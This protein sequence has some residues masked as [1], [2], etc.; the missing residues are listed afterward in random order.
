MV[1]IYLHFKG[2]TL[3]AGYLKK[4]VIQRVENGVEEGQK[5]MQGS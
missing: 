5:L 2:I 3:L 4:N 1:L